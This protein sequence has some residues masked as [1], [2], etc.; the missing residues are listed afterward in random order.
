M[1]IKNR[2]NMEISKITNIGAIPF[3][4]LFSLEP[5]LKCF[6]TY[7]F[8]MVLLTVIWFIIL[9]WYIVSVFK[10]STPV[11]KY[12]FDIKNMSFINFLICIFGFSIS[13]I[14]KYSLVKFW[15]VIFGIEIINYIINLKK[16]K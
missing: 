1:K 14:Y 7:W 2:A 15:V 3:L 6:Q 5:V 10:K 13:Y 8:F 11:Q 16:I 12:I 4:I 9:T